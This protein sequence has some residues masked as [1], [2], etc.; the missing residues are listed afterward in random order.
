MYLF[1]VLSVTWG[2]GFGCA[3]G[4]HFTVLLKQVGRERYTGVIGV[5]SLSIGFQILIIGPFVG[6]ISPVLM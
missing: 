5:S 1:I 4:L 2:F 3:M 6:K